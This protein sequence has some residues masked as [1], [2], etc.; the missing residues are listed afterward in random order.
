MTETIERE[1][2]TVVEGSVSSWVRLAR[3][4]G[5]AVGVWSIALQLLAGQVIPPVLVIGVVF[6]AMAIFLRGERRRLAAVFAGLSVLAVVGNLPQTIDELSNPSSAPAFILTLMVVVAAAVGLVAGLGAFFRWSADPVSAIAITGAAIVVGGAVVAGVA[7]AG[8]ESDAPQA[9]DTTVSLQGI[10]FGPEV[11]N[12]SAGEIGVW[13]DNRD[14]I[15]HS[16]TI[17]ELGVDLDV[18]GLK[19]QRTT[20]QA[21]VGEYVIF[22]NVPG[23]E[24]MT[25]T[26]M[27]QG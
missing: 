17:T 26:L 13:V 8:V 7:S 18:P 10:E 27:V 3:G 25:A 9:S 4:A 16:F 15:R 5:F 19:A 6:T 12:V 20:F 21:A 11:I 22:C 1:R 14:G 2:Q 23:H 24:K